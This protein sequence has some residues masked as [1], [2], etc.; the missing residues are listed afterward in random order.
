MIRIGFIGSGKMAS[1]LAS[2]ILRA[3]ITEAKHIICSDVLD[4][5]LEKIQ[6]MLNVVITKDNRQVIQNSDVVFLAIKPQNF[7][8][9]IV[10]VQNEFGADQ[11]VLSILAGVRIAKLQ[12]YLKGKIVRIMPNTA[13]L[14]GQMAAGYAVADNVGAKDLQTVEHLLN[15][16]GVAFR[17]SE[18]QLDAVTAVSGSGPAFVACFIDHY[19]AAGIQAGLSAEVSRRLTLQT[20]SGTATLLQEWKMDPEELIQMVSSPNGTTVAGREVLEASD[21]KSVIEAT[22]QRAAQRSCELGQ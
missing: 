10:D 16:A 20:F 14:V 22:I 21:L 12:Q 4:G 3:K 1:A 19:I 11:L 2:S 6:S 8:N 9:A 5:P 18:D 7:P 15:S 17:V 13:C